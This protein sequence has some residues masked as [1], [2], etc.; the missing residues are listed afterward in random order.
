M[1]DDPKVFANILTQKKFIRDLP[2]VALKFKADNAV[3]K[4]KLNDFLK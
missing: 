2:H 3:K 4:K 1:E